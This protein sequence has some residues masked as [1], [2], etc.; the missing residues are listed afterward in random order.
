MHQKALGSKG[1]ATVWAG[2]KLSLT[3]PLARYKG[4]RLLL[5]GWPP[6]LPGEPVIFYFPL[7]QALG[8]MNRK[9]EGAKFP[10]TNVAEESPWSSWDA[11]RSFPKTSKVIRIVVVW[12]SGHTTLGLAASLVNKKTVWQERA[13]TGFAGQQ[14]G[15]RTLERC[16]VQCL[17]SVGPIAAAQGLWL[18]G[19]WPPL[20][21]GQLAVFNSPLLQALGL[22]NGE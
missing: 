19:F 11:T 3:W 13:A 4:L 12:W 21:L 1:P 5:W 7:F 10:A 17:K 16:L 14:L 20:V 9:G 15:L 2:L 8:L 22:M 18:G 6:E